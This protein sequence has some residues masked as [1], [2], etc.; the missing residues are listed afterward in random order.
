[1]SAVLH[2]YSG[3]DVV[4][5]EVV[6]PSTDEEVL[7]ALVAAGAAGRRATLRGAGASFHDQALNAD[8]LISVGGVPSSVELSGRE[9][10]VRGPASWGDVVEAGADC[11]LIPG[12]VPTSGRITVAGSVASDSVGRFSGVLGRVSTSLEGFDLLSPDGAR[13]TI[14]RPTP[15]SSEENDRLFRAV[16]GGHGYLGYTTDIR[17]LLVPLGEAWSADGPPPRVQTE[18]VLSTSLEHAAQALVGDYL[19]L[20]P[21]PAGQEEAREALGRSGHTG[22]WLITNTRGEGFLFRSRLVHGDTPLRPFFLHQPGGVAHQIA[23]TASVSSAWNQLGWRATW[24]AMQRNPAPYVDELQGFLFMMDGNW[25]AR[26]RLFALGL[27]PWLLQQSFAMPIDRTDSSPALRAERLL[28]R[29]AREFHDAGLAL[30]ALDLL[31]APA[32]DT[33]LCA[34]PG[35]ESVLVTPVVQGLL[36]RTSAK[37]IAVYHRLSRFAAELGGRV[38]L[39]KSVYVEP[40][41]MQEMYGDAVRELDALRGL[42]DPYGVL[43]NRFLER[44]RGT[45]AGEG[46]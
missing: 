12:I 37:V 40:D 8:Q 17:T 28:E 4:R 26:A 9:A 18:M 30:D 43:Q 27:R 44:I 35:V 21:Q 25:L 6:T 1:M 33:L 19:A 5:P 22:P 23:Q 14:V 13:R 16:P 10:C 45:W 15:G 7:D 42:V 38:H 20:H 36:P 29:V 32:D 41:V 11:G 34:A 24:R 3:L 2:S 31:V 39:T 46:G